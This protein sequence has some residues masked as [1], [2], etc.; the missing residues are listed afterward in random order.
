MLLINCFDC[1]ISYSHSF[2]VHVSNTSVWEKKCV[3]S[4]NYEVDRPRGVVKVADVWNE[5]RDF[6]FKQYI[7]ILEIGF[8]F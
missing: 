7:V 5:N 2:H 4:P 6:D 8:G 1:S 3:V